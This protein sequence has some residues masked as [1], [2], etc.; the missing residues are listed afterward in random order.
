MTW[1][2]ALLLIIVFLIGLYC[3][4]ASTLQKYE[5][6][7]SARDGTVTFR[8]NKVTGRLQRVEYGAGGTKWKDAKPEGFFKE[9][10]ENIIRLQDK[11]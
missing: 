1:K 8:F 4:L 9:P 6:Y 2:E 7:Q 11:E 3:V 10:G 5:V